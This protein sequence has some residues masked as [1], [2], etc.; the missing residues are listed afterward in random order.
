M[1]N[2]DAVG[3][4]ATATTNGTSLYTGS[5]SRAPKQEMDGEMFLSLLVTQLANQDPS[6]PMDT[7]EMISQT[8]QLATMERLTAM[9]AQQQESF[10][11][12]MRSS[13]AALI[14]RDVEYTDAAGKTVTGTAASVSF[15][16]P[17]PL[18]NVGGAAVALDQISSVRS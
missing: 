8:T 4:T 13:A 5:N 9:Q 14:G 15:A 12:Q 10:S 6:S 16:G 3:A 17:V 11:L 1:T 18:V 2:V 7:N